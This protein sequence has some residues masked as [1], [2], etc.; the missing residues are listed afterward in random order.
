VHLL[1][2]SVA[3]Q[4]VFLKGIYI[5]RQRVAT[6]SLVKSNASCLLKSKNIHE[7]EVVTDKNVVYGQV[8]EG[9][10]VYV[11]LTGNIAAGVP[12]PP[13]QLSL[14][15]QAFHENRL[16]F[17]VRVLNPQTA[18]VGRLIATERPQRTGTAVAVPVTA[19]LD[20]YLPDIAGA[21]LGVDSCEVFQRAGVQQ[22]SP[23]GRCRILCRLFSRNICCTLL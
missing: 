13:G 8:H 9:K 2:Y 10:S 17:Y 11:T 14:P 19:C 12:S 22:A 15:F 16:P 7:V 5:R 18:A 21:D 6:Q 20:V 3:K 1:A 4:N 23:T